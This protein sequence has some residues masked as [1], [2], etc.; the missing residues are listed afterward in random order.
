MI[1]V[2]CAVVWV[3]CGVIAAGGFL[4]YSQQHHPSLAE[5]DFDADC[6]EALVWSPLGPIALITA[7][8]S[9]GLFRYGLQYRPL[10]RN[11]GHQ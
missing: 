11:H 6:A 5:Q 9:T 1:F 7:A 3:M 4:A 8:I 2:V 10:R